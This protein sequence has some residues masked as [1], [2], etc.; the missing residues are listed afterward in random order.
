MKIYIPSSLMCWSFARKIVYFNK[1]NNQNPNYVFL[2]DDHVVSFKLLFCKHKKSAFSL[3]SKKK[4]AFNHINARA[5]ELHVAWKNVIATSLQRSHLRSTS[6]N[7]S[8]F[9]S[10]ASGGM[11]TSDREKRS[12]GL[13]LWRSI[14]FRQKSETKPNSFTGKN[15]YWIR[16][17]GGK[18]NLQ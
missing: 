2:A 16:M 7:I 13:L 6:E 8:S 5:E 11:A 4:P 1:I 10:T 14:A 15:H 18:N 12:P 9:A 17:L 3:I